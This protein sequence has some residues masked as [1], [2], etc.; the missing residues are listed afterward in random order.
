LL[1]HCCDIAATLLR[2]NT[3][4]HEADLALLRSLLVPLL[5]P[6]APRSVPSPCT[7]RA[8]VAR[9]RGEASGVRGGAGAAAAVL[10]PDLAVT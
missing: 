8:L 3:R 9:A 6:V 5:S 7:P 1:R 10:K 4:W 2:Q